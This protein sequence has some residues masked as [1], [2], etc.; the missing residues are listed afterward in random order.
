AR[1]LIPG[2]AR[3]A[4]LEIALDAVEVQVSLSEGSPHTVRGVRAAESRNQPL[5]VDNEVRMP[6]STKN[7]RRLALSA[8]VAA[9]STTAAC[10]ADRTLQP[11]EGL[12]ARSATGSSADVGNAD[13]N[14]LLATIREA[15]ARYQRVD[16]AIADGYVQGSPCESMPGQGIGIHFR[17]S[18]LFDA[19]VDP[20]H[21]ELLVYEP[22]ANGNI[23][24]VAV[25]FVVPAAA[26]DPTH[27][28]PPMLGN[29][30]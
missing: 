17:K 22:H 7:L 9:V 1:S 2:K 20:S 18:S 19:I 27:N 4:G 21:P 26:W 30:V 15:T 5:H 10:S 6:G 24:L 12:T 8:V 23:D 3:S 13:Q 25:A 11:S 29:Q 14:Q 28:A 16:A